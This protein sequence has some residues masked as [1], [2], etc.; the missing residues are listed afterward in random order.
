MEMVEILEN[1]FEDNFHNGWGKE[2]IMSFEKLN[3]VLKEWKSTKCN[4]HLET[5]GMTSKKLGHFYS[6]KKGTF[7]N[8]LTKDLNVAR[9]RY[10]S[11]KVSR[12]F[13]PEASSWFQN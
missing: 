6:Y 1:D 9:K 3:L 8:L 11:E 2:I 10:F 12:K 4:I 7:E 13:K 5:G